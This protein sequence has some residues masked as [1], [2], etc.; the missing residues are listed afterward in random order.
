MHGNQPTQK[1]HTNPVTVQTAGPAS[2]AA[3]TDATLIGLSFRNPERFAEVFDRHAAEIFRYASGRL[4]PAAADDVTAETFLAA[5][6]RR[7]SYDLGRDDARP[8][9]YGIAIRQ[10]GEHRRAERRHYQAMVRL[11]VP[12]ADEAFEDAAADRVTATQVLPQIA[13]A[14][15]AISPAERDLLLLVAWTDLS[16]SAI[17]Q[18]LDLAPGTVA[19][20][21][22]R[23]RGKV[24]RLLDQHDHS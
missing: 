13:R 2:R 11:P 4:G 1:G 14:L 17:A 23:I 5:F 12:R 15:A 7:S 16:Y 3:L 21:L 8:W 18:A 24:R 6:R 10:I 22:H 9:L 20:R 19:S